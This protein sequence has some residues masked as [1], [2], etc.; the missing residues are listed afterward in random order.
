[1]KQ[2]TQTVLCTC[3]TAPSRS[4]VETVRNFPG[5]SRNFRHCLEDWWTFRKC[6]ETF[7][8]IGET[9]RDLR[10]HLRTFSNALGTLGTFRES[11][12]T[13]GNFRGTFGEPLGTRGPLGNHRGR[14]GT[15]GQPA[16]KLRATCKEASESF[17]DPSGNQ[18]GN[19]SAAHMK[20]K[21]CIST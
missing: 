13:F 8:H 21:I 7:G 20:S 16:R 2:Q 19:T 1:M 5:P 6:Q 17:Q 12:V 3:T 4:P 10:V 18:Q 11:S 15:F 14:S 9:S